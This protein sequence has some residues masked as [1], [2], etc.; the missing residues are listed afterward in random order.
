MN[1][2]LDQKR[3]EGSSPL[4]QTYHENFTTNSQDYSNNYFSLSSEMSFLPN[5]FMDNNVSEE[6]P[7][8]FFLY[9]KVIALLIMLFIEAEATA[10]AEV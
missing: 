9:F 10:I 4:S 3:I 7:Q 6:Q 8:H 1:C 5:I 2:S